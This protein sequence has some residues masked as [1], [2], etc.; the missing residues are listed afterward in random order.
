MQK[1]VSIDMQVQENSTIEKVNYRM[2]PIFAPY[3]SEVESMTPFL[4][5][6]NLYLRRLPG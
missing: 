1:T 5:M 2:P 3:N 4:G 6:K